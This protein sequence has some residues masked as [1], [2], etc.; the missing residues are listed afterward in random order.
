MG[1]LCKDT[2]K[3]EIIPHLPLPRRGKSCDDK[4]LL[5]IVE[6]ILYR[7]KTGCQWRELPIKQYLEFDYSYQ[8]VFITFLVGVGWGFGKTFGWVY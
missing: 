5:G 6:L 7:I 8:S 1:L 4:L 2:I 3:N